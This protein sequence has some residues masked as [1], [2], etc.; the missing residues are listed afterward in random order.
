VTV[1][2]K[3]AALVVASFVVAFVA[4]HFISHGVLI[5]S[6]ASLETSHVHTSTAQAVHALGVRLEGLDA[7]NLDWASWDNTYDF[8]LTLSPQYIDSNLVDGT[9]TALSVNAIVILD[10]S[11]GI[12]FAKAF[13]FDNDEP[14][15]VPEDLVAHLTDDG[16]LAARL[17]AHETTSGVLSLADGIM[18][19]STRPIMT[20]DE[21]GPPHGSFVM[22]V[23]VS[24]QMLQD[25]S[26]V[27]MLSVAGTPLRESAI[28]PDGVDVPPFAKPAGVEVTP[29]GP[30]LIEGS[31]VTRDLYGQPVY[32]LSVRQSR[33][34]YA[35]GQRTLTF[36]LTIIAAGGVA[37]ALLFLI[38]LDRA[39]LSRLSRLAANVRAVG[40]QP[41]FSGEVAVDGDDDIGFLAAT[42]NET[43]R[44]LTTTHRQLEAS[45]SEL[46]R[47]NAD[48][49][50][51]E[52][53]LGSTA[54]QLRRL[55]RH[56]QS[57]RE[58][59]QA[60]V[61]KEIRDQ[62]G[63]GLTAVKMDLAALQRAT[64]RGDAPSTE[65]I[66]RMTALIDTLLDTV[67]RLSSGLHPSAL[68]DLGLAEGFEWQL[69]EFGRERAIKTTFRIQGPAS[70][71]DASRALT[72]FRIL[73]EAL[74]VSAEDPATTEVSVSLD[75]ENT[76]ALLAIRDNGTTILDGAAGARR[77]IG[78]SLIRE[79]SEIFG[80][81]ITI[82]SSLET[83]TSI[84]VQLPL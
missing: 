55:T 76:Y 50:R 62:V 2:L 58:D 33:D 43:L 9:F 63:Q 61:A 47:T 28:G 66:Q 83:G 16:Y 65:F 8:V 68:E 7:T 75:I 77:E 45:H 41:D 42:I 53:E 60:F 81:G 37:L 79:R 38:L 23:F 73:Q 32:E 34:I 39:I 74:L 4:V 84:V 64:D 26:N 72:L 44:A 36:L 31:A 17:S 40:E 15:E 20:S 30:D 14:S 78:L 1:R 35:E 10:S 59:E 24:E 27:T 71:V 13:D 70:S 49:K 48:L 11:G 46:E 12:V 5:P 25:I 67:R 54:N 22:A 80:G 56:L 52:Q 69:T 18:L 51:T 19:I 82:D 57:M 29:L 21:T 3:A 6:Y